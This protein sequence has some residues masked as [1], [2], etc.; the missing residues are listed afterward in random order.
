MAVLSNLSTR[1]TQLKPGPRNRLLMFVA[2]WI[3]IV[4]LLS[5]MVSCQVLS[6]RQEPVNVHQEITATDNAQNWARSYL[7]LWLGGTSKKN[8]DSANL[9]TL[10]SMTSAPVDLE[11]PQT[12][13]SVQDIS[14]VSA[15]PTPIDGDDVIWRM[16]QSA[17]VVVP[18]TNK[19]TRMVY[20]MDML[21]HSGGYQATAT[22]RVV[23]TTTVPFEVNTVYTNEAQTDSAMGISAQAFADAYF[24][25][26]SGGN[27][28]STVG[29]DFNSQ[30][31]VNSPYRKAKVQ[32]VLFYA[33]DRKF[34]INNVKPG[35]TVHALITVKA[36]TSSTT[37]NITQVPVS[38]SVLDNGQWVV[39]QM[40]PAV[41]VGE[42]RAR[43]G[44]QDQGDSTQ[45]GGS[46]YSSTDSSSNPLPT[47]GR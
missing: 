1:F 4:P 24:T 6:T 15:E 5:L 31:L 21:E 47:R 39:G 8:E 26:G 20:D 23:T 17:T 40:E 27:L 29:P 13:Y 25:P 22:P 38:M 45:Q 46:G 19:V 35:D 34:D 11:L 30:A 10:Q 7:L 12:G 3:A 28:G 9:K 16:R 44:G 33:E 43:Q 14:P 18:G 32:S 2:V 37:F 42:T 36:E 41:D